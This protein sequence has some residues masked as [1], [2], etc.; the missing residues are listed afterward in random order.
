MNNKINRL[1]YLKSRVKKMQK[2]DEINKQDQNINPNVNNYNNYKTFNNFTGSANTI[3]MFLSL[4]ETLEDVI[5]TTNN[6]SD[7]DFVERL[8]DPNRKSISDWE[9]PNF[10]ATHK[11]GWFEDEYGAVVF[12]YVQNIDGKL[13]DFTDPKN[14]GLGDPVESA[15]SRGDYIEFKSGE[16]AD[17]YTKNYKKFYPSFEESRDGSYEKL[18]EGINLIN[19]IKPWIGIYREKK[20]K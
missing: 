5:K 15:L 1:S 17:E 3:R 10:I 2:G 18:K 20:Y 7:I 8:K 11:L 19:N 6:R 9:D 14:K 12:P 4:N 13:Y 16:L